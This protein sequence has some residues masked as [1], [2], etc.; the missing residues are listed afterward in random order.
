M[1]I[2]SLTEKVKTYAMQKLTL[3]IGLASKDI[4]GRFVTADTSG[5]SLSCLLIE[6]I[7]VACSFTQLYSWCIK[8]LDTNCWQIPSTI[9]CNLRDTIFHFNTTDKYKHYIKYSHF[10]YHS[11]NIMD[12]VMQYTIFIPTGRKF[13]VH[14]DEWGILPTLISV[15]QQRSTYL[16]SSYRKRL[17]LPWRLSSGL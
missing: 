4:L 14:A 15:W 6:L 12:G 2:T 17:Y 16:C 7:R 9:F 1:F 5:K 13:S 11:V 10:I 3:S 8:P